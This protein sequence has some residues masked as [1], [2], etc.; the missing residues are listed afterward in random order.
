M[1]LHRIVQT[2]PESIL[3]TY[4]GKLTETDMRWF[5]AAKSSTYSGRSTYVHQ[6]PIL[7]GSGCVVL[8]GI[9]LIGRGF[10]RVGRANALACVVLLGIALIGSPPAFGHGGVVA[11]ED[12]CLLKMGFLQA[13]FTLFLPETRGAEEF[14]EDLPETGRALF[15]V[16]YLHEMMKETP[17]D[18]RIITDSRGFGI[19]ANW[20]DVSSIADIEA[21]TVFHRPLAVEPTGLVTVSHTFD[22]PGGYIGIIVAENPINGN[23]YN[24]VFYFEVGNAGYGYIPLFVGLIVAAQLLFFTSTG[25]LQ[26][27]LHHCWRRWHNRHIAD[28]Q[29]LPPSKRNLP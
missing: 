18:F 20:E 1:L 17:V 10:G 9:A 5:A 25:S 12:L 26:R 24:A 15:V 11:E 27:F 19:F 29:P 7:S 3:G 13:H 14:C 8:L 4:K 6:S 21:Q 28:K 22:E 23:I 2:F 16:E